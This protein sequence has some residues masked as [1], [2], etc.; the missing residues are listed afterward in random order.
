MGDQGEV[1]DLSGA[2]K[3]LSFQPVFVGPYSIVYRGKLKSNDE[4]VRIQQFSESAHWKVL[5]GGHQG[6]E[7]NS[8]CRPPYHAKGEDF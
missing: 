4:M 6:F 5:L 2:V 1:P 3:M 7:P 8:W